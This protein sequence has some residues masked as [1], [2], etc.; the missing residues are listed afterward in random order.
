MTS[1]VS[2][3]EGV[4][5]SLCVC[6]AELPIRVLA[7]AET[8]YGGGLSWQG[9]AKQLE[10]TVKAGDK[11]PFEIAFYKTFAC[12]SA[13][14]VEAARHNLVCGTRHNRQTFAELIEH[15]QR[16]GFRD[17]APTAEAAEADRLICA[18]TPCYECGYPSTDYRAVHQTGSYIP[19]AVCPSCGAAAEL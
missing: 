19:F 14:F 4:L 10:E 7:A 5:S 18:T 1:E 11:Q 2:V 6:G 15:Y 12:E 8:L 13:D 16:A 17:G 9:W 3:R